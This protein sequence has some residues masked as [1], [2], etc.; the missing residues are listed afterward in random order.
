MLSSYFSIRGS[1]HCLPWSL[2]NMKYISDYCHHM[3][4]LPLLTSRNVHSPH[5]QA[6]SGREIG[7]QCDASASPAW[8]QRK[9][10]TVSVT[11]PWACLLA[12]RRKQLWFSSGLWF[13]DS[14]SVKQRAMKAVK[15]QVC[16]NSDQKM[17]AQPKKKKKAYKVTALKAPSYLLT[18]YI[19]AHPIHLYCSSG[20]SHPA[21]WEVLI[22]HN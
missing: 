22:I 19:P 17:K 9:L 7:G 20:A 4:L 11:K 8:C 16:G 1:S 10:R 6:D 2:A 15:E 3:C 12:L 5:P 13:C 18:A 14:N 21:N